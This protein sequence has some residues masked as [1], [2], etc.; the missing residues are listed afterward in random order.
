MVPYP[1]SPVQPPPPAPLSTP[2]EH[3]NSLSA[4]ASQTEQTSR[5]IHTHKNSKTHTLKDR[6]KLLIKTI[7]HKIAQVI[8]TTA[9][10]HLHLTFFVNRWQQSNSRPFLL[11]LFLSFTHYSFP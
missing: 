10:R 3:P 7:T 5:H 6:H 11:R 2:V 1:P 4:M 9:P 8:S